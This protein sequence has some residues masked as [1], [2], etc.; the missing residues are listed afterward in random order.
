MPEKI[1]KLLENGSLTE[2]QIADKLN[3]SVDEVKA[4]M[5][6]LKMAGIIKSQIINP[7]NSGGCSGNCGGCGGC[8]SSYNDTSH[9]GYTIWEII[10]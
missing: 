7:K 9:S 1:L 10:D 8:N 2:W 5:E 4:C 3:I 6:Y